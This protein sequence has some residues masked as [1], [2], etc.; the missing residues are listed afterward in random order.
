MINNNCTAIKPLN[1]KN[2]VPKARKKMGKQQDFVGKKLI[3]DSFEEQDFF[4]MGR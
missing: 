4:Y 1:I 2:V 3:Y